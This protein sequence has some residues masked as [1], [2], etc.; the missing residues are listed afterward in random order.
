MRQAVILAGGKGTRLAKKS[1]GLPKAMVKVNGVP[2]LEHI[3]LECKKN[4]I[5][6]VTLL[7]SHKYEVIQDYFGDGSL[8]GVSLEYVID[9]EARGTAHA[10]LGC[11]D[12]LEEEFVVIYGDTYFNVNL[13]KMYSYHRTL[14]S[15]VTLFAHPNDHPFD[16]DLIEISE[17]N[18]I[19]N[20]H[21]Y[22]HNGND[23]QILSMQHYI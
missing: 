14:N 9:N 17:N 11:I 1:L 22:P 7:V 13:R 16:S 15:D 8:W 19:T 2:V 10:L 12:S 3:I 5:T 4:R 23:Y 20:I 18:K 21:S 6:K